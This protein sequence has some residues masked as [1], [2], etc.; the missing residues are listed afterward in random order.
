MRVPKTLVL[1]FVKGMWGSNVVP[2]SY[3]SVPWYGMS[4]GRLVLDSRF[5]PLRAWFS[6]NVAS[7]NM[8]TI[9]DWNVKLLSR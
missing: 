8:F 7:G 6:N 4:G 3:I 1:D 2:V 9:S 5:L